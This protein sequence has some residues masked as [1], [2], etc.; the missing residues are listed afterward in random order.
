MA[1]VLRRPVQIDSE[2][3]HLNYDNA[4]DAG[5]PHLVGAG[6]D[7][8]C[9]LE[10][11]RLFAI[12]NDCRQ[13]LLTRAREKY[14]KQEQQAEIKRREN[15]P[16]KREFQMKERHGTPLH[17]AF[18]WTRRMSANAE[19]ARQLRQWQER[20]GR[21]RNNLEAEG[22]LLSGGVWRLASAAQFR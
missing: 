22:F 17:N 14:E 8:V 12:I 1:A 3:T 10:R 6:S 16:V 4:T 21:C 7:E 18:R 13:D 9:T 2:N 5:N 19:R 15:R 20:V 11:D